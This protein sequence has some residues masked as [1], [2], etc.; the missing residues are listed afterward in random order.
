MGPL[1]PTVQY[2]DT[3]PRPPTPGIVWIYLTVFAALAATGLLAVLYET[4]ATARYGRTL[5]KMWVHIR[6]LQ[7]DGRP[8]GTGRA[9]GRATLY[10]LSTVLGWIGI[11]DP[12]WCLWDADRQCVHDKVVG[13]IVVDD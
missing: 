6:P 2:Q 11:L 13:T 4:V 3:A 9:L 12:L 1:F 8:L 10:W 5:G 7:I